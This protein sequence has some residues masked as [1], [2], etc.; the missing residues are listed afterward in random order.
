MDR[1][2]YYEE[3]EKKFVN[4]GGSIVNKDLNMYYYYKNELIAV[5]FEPSDNFYFRGV[6]VLSTAISFIEKF[7][8]GVKNG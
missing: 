2:K 1:R 4:L 6:D 8:K 7:F 5:I 3:L